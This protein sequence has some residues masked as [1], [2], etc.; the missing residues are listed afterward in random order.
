MTA[1]LESQM[2]IDLLKKVLIDYPR[3]NYPEY[4]ALYT[5]TPNWRTR[6]LMRLDSLFRSKNFAICKVVEPVPED[7]IV[8]KDWP[9]YADTMIGMKRLENIEHCVKKVLEDKIEGDFIETGVWRGG[10]TILMRAMLKAHNVT[11]RTVWVADSFEGLPKP[12]ADKYA[13]DKGDTHHTMRELMISKEIVEDNFRKYGL[14]DNQ[15]QFLKGWFKDTLPTAPIKKVAIARLD[16]D[17]YES[18]MDGITNLYPKLSVGGFLLVDDYGGLEGCRR[19]IDD[20]RKQHGITEPIIK[21]D[22][23]GVYWRKEKEI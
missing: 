20:Y 19:A 17:M 23:T 7:R 14:L 4:K 18:T 8:G 5:F 2:Y 9:V 21:V 11:D 10:A 22:W 12:D 3:L 1:T 13:A 15:V 16:G 6:L